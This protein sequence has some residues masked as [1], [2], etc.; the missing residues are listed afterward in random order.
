M[1]NLFDSNKGD[2][3]AAWGVDTSTMNAADK[4]SFLEGNKAMKAASAKM[5]KDGSM[6]LL[7]L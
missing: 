2:M 3:V 6:K 7:Y 4:A 5:L 1:I